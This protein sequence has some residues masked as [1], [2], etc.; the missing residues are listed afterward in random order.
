MESSSPTPGGP[1][2]PSQHP[3]TTITPTA[4][5]N[6]STDATLAQVF[7]TTAK[8]QVT[9]GATKMVGWTIENAK[10]ETA[11]HAKGLRPIHVRV[12][13]RV[14][15]VAF[16]H[17][18]LDNGGRV[19]IS[20]RKWRKKKKKN[21]A[22]APPPGL[23][24]FG[25]KKGDWKNP[26]SPKS[27]SPFGTKEEGGNN[28]NNNV[29][30]LRKDFN[31]EDVMEVS[32]I[33]EIISAEAFRLSRDG[34][35]QHH[36]AL[37]QASAQSLPT[38]NQ[39]RSSRFGLSARRKSNPSVPQNNNNPHSSMLSSYSAANPEEARRYYK[40]CADRP[41]GYR[42]LVVSS[43]VPTYDVP[44][45]PPLTTTPAHKMM[46][47]ATSSARAS[48]GE[49][50]SKRVPRSYKPDNS[51]RS[52][53]SDPKQLRRSSTS[54]T[55][56]FEKNISAD[57]VAEKDKK[58]NDQAAKDGKNENLFDNVEYQYIG[59]PQT[60]PE[61]FHLLRTHGAATFGRY[62]PEVA[63]SVPNHSIG[64]EVRK[65]KNKKRYAS[66]Q[67][68]VAE[69]PHII[70]GDARDKMLSRIAAEGCPLIDSRKFE[71]VSN[72]ALD[73]TELSESLMV[74]GATLW[75]QNADDDDVST[76]SITKLKPHYKGMVKAEY[77]GGKMV[78]GV[79][80][81]LGVGVKGLTKGTKEAVH[82]VGK[83]TKGVVDG[84]KKLLPIPHDKELESESQSTTQAPSEERTS[85]KSSKL[86]SMFNPK[87]V[88][89]K[90]RRRSKQSSDDGRSVDGSIASSVGNDDLSLG[91][92]NHSAHITESVDEVR[93]KNFDAKDD[94]DDV[95]KQ[96]E[97][98]DFTFVKPV[99][100]TLL[101]DD[102]IDIRIVSFPDK[103]DVIA[104]FPISVASVMVQRSIEDRTSDPLKPSELTATLIQEPSA[105]QL[106]W[107]V[108][109][110]VTLRAVEVKPQ[111]PRLVPRTKDIIDEEMSKMKDRL[112]QL[113]KKPEDIKKDLQ[114][115]EEDI[116]KEENDLNEAIVAYGYGR[117]ENE[118]AGHSEVRLRQMFYCEREHGTISRKMQRRSL[119][120]EDEKEMINDATLDPSSL[121]KGYDKEEEQKLLTLLDLNFP[122]IEKDDDDD[123]KGAF[124][125]LGAE[126][127]AVNTFS[128]VGDSLA[129]ASLGLAQSLDTCFAELAE[130]PTVPLVQKRLQR[131]TADGMRPPV[132]KNAA[133]EWCLQMAEK[134]ST[135]VSSVDMTDATLKSSIVKLQSIVVAESTP[136]SRMDVEEGS[137]DDTVKEE[138]KLSED[139]IAL[140]QTKNHGSQSDDPDSSKLVDWVTAVASQLE[141]MAIELD[142]DQAY[143]ET[144]NSTIQGEE[145][146]S[147]S[148]VV[149]GQGGASMKDP[150]GFV[151]GKLSSEIIKNPQPQ[152]APLPSS[153]RR[154]SEDVL[155]ENVLSHKEQSEA[156]SLS[157]SR[158]RISTAKNALSRSKSKPK[159]QIEPLL[160][161]MKKSHGHSLQ[162][163]MQTSSLPATL[164][165]FSVI[166][167]VLS[168]GVYLSFL[169][170]QE[171]WSKMAMH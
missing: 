59:P 103:D 47:Y 158:Q 107:G 46:A 95:A 121:T 22:A 78:D 44:L 157:N 3:T 18:G 48:S 5:S 82:A 64:F 167:T 2:T 28:N 115:K 14:H 165:C 90:L 142:D 62:L 143:S 7:S 144:L 15:H 132:T 129:K 87:K 13:V 123:S 92:E 20:D 156:R 55:W 114:A 71:Y 45:P 104:N 9:A 151:G 8:G 96:T 102:I 93:D 137:I 126:A 89:N 33:S 128:A 171:V 164:V 149:G 112:S 50:G 17:P 49:L 109:L 35:I 97:E 43:A 58:K 85:R 73:D 77:Y 120:T 118:G 53:R 94:Q 75:V 163:N 34:I 79:K 170:S 38:T 26:I 162:V 119:L 147:V 130:K 166:I 153:Q 19:A 24:Q 10:L 65:A 108:E 136:G 134:L 139:E 154:A 133:K 113:G 101:L 1:P 105:Q 111:V 168:I 23:L 66:T 54:T 51:G 76:S 41:K 159:S 16:L 110:K 83:G 67:P 6:T 138:M 124:P 29:T 84:G 36:Y 88:T 57:D 81:G 68:L 12:S 25:H 150:Q 69:A 60:G 161:M 40:E 52:L 37:N 74:C 56:D 39:Q 70:W 160:E 106:R 155:W 42:R 169:F 72:S 99:P 61:F 80:E 86:K 11:T 117:G 127:G 152:Q 140:S 146:Q 116:A 27:K 63:C 32:E 4:T 31:S 91:S 135:H 30:K 100:Y 141:A 98:G 131:T 21:N 145:E 125:N 122:G 148:S